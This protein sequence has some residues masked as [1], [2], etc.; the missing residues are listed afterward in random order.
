MTPRAN[1]TRCP[2]RF[3]ASRAALM[4][5]AV[6][7]AFHYLLPE[8]LTGVVLVLFVLVVIPLLMAGL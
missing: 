3:H 7:Y 5:N 1:T 2:A 4:R 8:A 6:Y